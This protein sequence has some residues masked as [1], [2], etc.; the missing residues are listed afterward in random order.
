MPKEAVL[1]RSEL[2]KKLVEVAPAS[3]VFPVT[4]S[5]P[6]MVAFPEVSVP[7]EAVCAK[8]LVEDAT[9]AKS[10]VVVA[11]VSS[12]LPN[13]VVEANCTP[14][15]ALKAPLTVEEPVM[16][17][18]VVV[19]EPREKE[20]PEMRPVFDMEKSVEVA[21]EEDVDATTKSVVF[22]LVE[23]AWIERLA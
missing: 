11:L 6:L 13:S 7:K 15:V 3:V 10:E 9:E 18:L 16:A 14:P 8:R 22:T 19:P 5:V 2:V 12:V 17:R 20:R 21:P 4:V 1:A 23:A